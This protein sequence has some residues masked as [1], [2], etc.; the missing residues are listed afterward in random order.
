MAI[1]RVTSEERLARIA[2]IARQ[3]QEDLHAG[4]M[5]VARLQSQAFA[6]LLLTYAT[7]AMLSA[8]EM[9]MNESEQPAMP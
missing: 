7:P 8:A 4:K 9:L 6:M 3:I 2:S 5:D 1:A